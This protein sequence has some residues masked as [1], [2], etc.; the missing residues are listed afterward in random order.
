MAYK[1]HQLAK[2]E[3]RSQNNV[4]RSPRVVLVI[5]IQYFGHVYYMRSDLA[6]M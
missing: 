5:Y 4:S 6:V 1:Q 3:L 2:M